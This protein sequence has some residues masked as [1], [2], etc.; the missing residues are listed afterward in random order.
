V[1]AKQET[2]E[3]ARSGLVVCMQDSCKTGLAVSES[4]PRNA[5]IRGVRPPD[6]LPIRFAH[7][8]C[9]FA[10]SATD[11][12]PLEYNG[13]N[14]ADETSKSIATQGRPI[15]LS[16]RSSLPARRS[17]RLRVHGAPFSSHLGHLGH[18]LATL[19]MRTRGQASVTSRPAEAE[20]ARLSSAAA[21]SPFTPPCNSDVDSIAEDKS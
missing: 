10:G 17:F 15:K 19:V 8:G 20:A 7:A 2:A 1:E 4:H 16:K 14:A 9:A 12:L 5:G 21:S 11:R 18:G 6:L 13:P 3:S